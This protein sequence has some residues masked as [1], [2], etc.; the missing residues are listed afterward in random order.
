MSTR[1]LPE[2][3]VF[4]PNSIAEA[5]A[6][7]TEHK[8]HI[9]IM[10]GGTDLLVNMKGGMKCPKDESDTYYV[11]SL[12]QIPGLDSVEYDEKEGL[13]IGAM[14]TLTQVGDYPIVKDMYVALWE[15]VSVCG[16]RQTRNMGTAIGNLLNASPCADISCAVLALGGAVVLEG[17]NGRRKVDIDDFWSGYRVTARQPDEVAVAVELPPIADGV[18]SS[19]SKMRRV[20]HDL[21]KLSVAVRLDMSGKNCRGARI[22]MGSVAPLVIRITKTEKLLAGVEITDNILA[23]VASSVSSEINPIDDVRSTAEYRREVGGVLVRRTIQN[24][25]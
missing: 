18:L 5:V 11:L 14:A 8:G 12:S 9:S 6:L 17:P 20:T 13:R 24:A 23:N 25:R 3:Q 16:T 22:A 19:H 21:A 2:F 7:L 15:A 10:A 1:I 4:T